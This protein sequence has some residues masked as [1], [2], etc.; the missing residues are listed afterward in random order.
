MRACQQGFALIAA[1]V[2]VVVLAALAGFVASMVGGQ[3]AGAQLERSTQVVERA[4][5]TGLEWGAY[6]ALRS[7]PASCVASTTLPAIAAYP[8]V[9]VRVTCAASPT[10][11]PAVPS[12][13]NVTVYRIVSTATAGGAPASPDYAERTR[14]GIFSR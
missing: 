6:R 7:V 2:L 9:T 5:Q 13:G 14:T 4:A 10:N 3:G 8:G 1:I 11:E 12:P